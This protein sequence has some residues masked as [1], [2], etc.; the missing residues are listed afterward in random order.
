MDKPNEQE[1]NEATLDRVTGGDGS[2]KAGYYHCTRCGWLDP[3]PR[4]HEAFPPR[5]KKCGGFMAWAMSTR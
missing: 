5:C 3:D 2:E 1:L 4:P